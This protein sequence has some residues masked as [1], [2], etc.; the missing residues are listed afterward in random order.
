[1]RNAVEHSVIHHFADDTNLLCSDKEPSQLRQKMNEDLKQI[2]E[3]VCSNR[4]S[5]NV[6]KTS[7]II[8]KPHKKIPHQIITLK[9]NGI[10]IYESYKIRYLGLIM[11][12]RLTWKQHISELSK[13]L[14]IPII[15][16]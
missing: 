16:N 1:M 7:F 12:D 8:F 5:L 11:D 9:L 2:F 15:Q 6:S 13:K 10:T 3:W 14:N 4:L